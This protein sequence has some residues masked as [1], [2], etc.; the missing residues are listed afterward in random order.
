MKLYD[1]HPQYHLAPEKVS[2]YGSA[3][4]ITTAT[5]PETATN[6]HH[7][8]C[9]GEPLRCRGSDRGRVKQRYLEKSP[10]GFSTARVENLF[11]VL[12]KRTRSVVVLE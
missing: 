6:Y 10:G 8:R 7:R 12:Q 9:G 1:L 4:P 2:I 5:A 11:S 3:V